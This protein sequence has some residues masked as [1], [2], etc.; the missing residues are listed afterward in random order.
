MKINKILL[1]NFNSFEGL[2]VLNFTDMPQDKNIILIGGKNG[3]GKTSLFTA[4]KIALYGPLAFGYMG[5][6]PHY[7]ARIKDCINSKA[8]QKDKVESRVQITI[9]LMVDRE[10][11]EY[12]ITREWDYSRQK[13]EEMYF[14]KMNGKL[15]NED[16]LSYFQNYLQSIVPPDLFEFFLFDGEEVGNIFSTST[17]NT[18]VKN[19]VYTLCG[20]DTFEIIRKYMKNYVGKAVGE[21]EEKLHS[22]YENLRNVVEELEN[23]QIEFKKEIEQEKEELAQ[24][25]TELIELE[26]AFKKAG[27]ITK[28]ERNRLTKE[29]EKA[30]KEKVES[31][32]EIKLFVEGLMPFYILK[33]FTREIT[34][35]LEQEEK[36]RIFYY[37]QQKLDQKD[38][39][40]A[41][42]TDGRISD[43][44]ID[45]LIEL[46]LERFKPEGF[47][48]G[49]QPLHDL[50]KEDTR[51]VHAMISNVDNFD[52]QAMVEAVLKKQQASECTAEIHKILKNAMTDEDAMEFTERENRLLRRR[53]EFIKNFNESNSKLRQL[54][55]SKEVAVQQRERALQRLKENVQNK[56]VLEL[57]TGL[58]RMMAAFLEN[59]ATAIR[60]KLEYLI[61][62]K[63]Q[64]IYRKN[65]LITHI[66]IEDDFEFHLYQDAVYSVTELAYLIRNLGKEG[67]LLGIGKKGQKALFQRYGVSNLRELQQI[68]AR[69]DDSESVNLYKR[70]DISRLSK[71]ERQIF[72]LSLY[73]AIIELS[74]QE[75]PF[76]IDTPYARIDANHRKEI[77]EKFFPN[78]SRQVIILSTDEEINEEYYQ[79]MKPYIGREFLLI[80]DENQNRTSVEPGYFFFFNFEEQ[81]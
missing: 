20:L 68:L 51:R 4:I 33:D 10:I 73:W 7:I 21:D 23:W 67:F 43:E 75:I 29:F 59:K 57:S 2:N 18:Y 64:L 60:T 49:I 44:S 48:E 19:A 71:G 11:R 61:I 41:I 56:H 72:I 14:I 12:E 24:V 40:H 47:K 6:T 65:N 36:D 50:S 58:T 5:M 42:A 39:R 3:A 16:E 77:S 22:Q 32:A 76:I 81:S 30:E 34:K 69:T 74:G 8:F 46:L 66:E 80:N 79:I 53:E 27:G 38:I 37:V 17:Y 15:L 9:S 25:E 26:H 45:F 52:S 62:E 1:Y 54:E 70:I 55:E 63:L 78:I 35:Q 13:L 31:T 28:K